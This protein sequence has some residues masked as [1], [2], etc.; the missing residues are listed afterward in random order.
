MPWVKNRWRT[1][2][3]R[4][5]SIK[6]AVCI[7]TPHSMVGLAPIS[8]VRVVATGE[9]IRAQLILRDPMKAYSRGVALA[10]YSA[11]R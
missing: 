9:T 2:V 3:A 7:P 5:A 1:F 8:L 6:P 4:L 11:N 10:K